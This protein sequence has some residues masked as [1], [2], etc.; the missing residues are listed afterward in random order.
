MEMFLFY[1][2]EKRREICAFFLFCAVFLTSFMLY[3]LPGKAVLYPAALCALIGMLFLYL[4]FRKLRKLHERLK[5]LRGMP[6]ELLDSLPPAYSIEDDD[7]QKIIASL[8][9][10]QKERQNRADA[11]YS[12]MIDYYTIWAHQIKT[13]IASMRLRLQ[14]EDSPSARQLTAELFRIE[15]YVEMALMFLNLDSGA[16]D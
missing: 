12:D 16:V 10:E 3:H 8:C 1:F 6:P 9:E 15:Q 4:D 5:E 13:P 11:R 2:K 14:N 7:Y